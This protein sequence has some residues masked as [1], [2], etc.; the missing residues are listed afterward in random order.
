MSANLIYYVRT[1]VIAGTAGGQSFNLP[2][3][4]GT[5]ADLGGWAKVTGLEVSWEVVNYSANTQRVGTLQLATSLPLPQDASSCSHF[6]ALKGLA[7]VADSAGGF[8]IHGW[9]PCV[10]RRCLAVSRGW[11]T[12][13][14]SLA[15]ERRGSLRILY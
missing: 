14:S 7:L 11:D 2:A 9:P 4:T 12:L 8:F 10:G 3:Q 5:G 13:L 1:G 6:S 15:R